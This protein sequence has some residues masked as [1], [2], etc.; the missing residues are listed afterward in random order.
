MTARQIDGQVTAIY[1]DKFFAIR[2]DADRHADGIELTNAA[3]DIKRMPSFVG[4]LGGTFDPV[5]HGH[6]IGARAAAELAGLDRL[7]LLPSAAPPHKPSEVMTDV[8]S[9]IEMLSLAIDGDTLFEISRFDAERP[10]PTFTIDTVLHFREVFP[11]EVKL[12]WLIGA[13]SL[14][15]LHT[16]H[17][18]SELVNAC[19]ILTLVRSGWESID[20]KPLTDCVGAEG[21][22]AL[23]DGLLVTPAIE[24]SSSEVRQRIQD[25]RSIRNLVPRSVESYVEANG[26]YRK[27]IP[28]ASDTTVI[29]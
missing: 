12:A 22:N 5:H 4:L 14:A 9:R 25:G 28:R 2:Q 3:R 6:L 21:V 27:P 15:D 8:E 24:I 16:W 10:G 18:V 26:L 7:I 20:W 19:R 13:D 17:R 23:R 29:P 1:D 11:A